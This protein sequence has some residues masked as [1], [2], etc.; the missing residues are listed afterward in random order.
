[1]LLPFDGGGT[2]TLTDDEILGITSAGR[3]SSQT[4]QRR[5]EKSGAKADGRTDDSPAQR[6]FWETDAAKA[7]DLQGK[8]TNKS[9]QDEDGE[10]QDADGKLPGKLKPVLEAHPELR[11][12]WENERAYRELFPSVEAAREI[13]KLFPTAEDARAAEEQ[14]GELRKLDGLFFSNQP[15]A[16]ATIAA[17]AYRLNPQAFRSL[18]R[19]MNAVLAP[20]EQGADT[21]DAGRALRSEGREVQSRATGQDS[22]EY[23]RAG[24]TRPEGSLSDAGQNAALLHEANAAAVQTILEDIKG[25]VDRLLPAEIAQGARNRVV[26]EIYREVDGSLRSNHALGQQMRQALHGG[27]L[28]AE[29]LRGLVSL[30]V[31]RAR[32]ALP[33][34]SRKVVSEWTTSV[35]KAQ[36]ER[37]SRQR[38]GEN[39]VDLMGAGRAESSRKRPTTPKDIDYGRMSDGEI[40][41]L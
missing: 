22:T 31:G 25:Q 29:Q 34:A 14:L 24:L 17:H 11:Q 23:R 4:M 5:K 6:D 21:G 12:V 10:S 19:M 28:S 39:R 1:M 13:H 35:L 18:V 8:E 32:Q 16:H 40:L 30:V 9:A 7:D 26:G 15:E 27:G 41:D 38:A 36:Q 33:G 3:G 37:H 20:G 2:A